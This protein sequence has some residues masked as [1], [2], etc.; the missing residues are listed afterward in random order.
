[1]PSNI[2]PRP[3]GAN[4]QLAIDSIAVDSQNIDRVGHWE[5]PGGNI[6][7]QWNN[8]APGSDLIMGWYFRWIDIE[9]GQSRELEEEFFSRDVG[10]RQNTLEEEFFSRTA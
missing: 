10:R 5:G 4:V 6:R 2:P 8:R 1:M 9:P 7:N 3:F